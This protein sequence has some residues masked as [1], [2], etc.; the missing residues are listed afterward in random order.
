MIFVHICKL[1][2]TLEK[3]FHREINEKLYGYYKVN[4]IDTHIIKRL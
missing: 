1:V 2:G 3:H 4:I